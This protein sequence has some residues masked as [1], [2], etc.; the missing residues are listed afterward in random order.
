MDKKLNGSFTVE[1]A[2][3][4]PIVL[5]IM[6][7]L[8][9]LGFYIHDRILL[10]LCAY[11]TG[12]E[13]VFEEKPLHSLAKEKIQMLNPLTIVP[14]STWTEG[15]GGVKV[16]YVGNFSIPF[17]ALTPFIENEKIKET[18]SVC[19]KMKLE[20]MYVVKIV[21]DKLEDEEK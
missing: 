19:G 15:N 12:M 17:T 20:K 18:K 10:G 16:T 13:S 11:Q 6:T 7:G 3:V 14:S 5:F 2:F 8:I 9:Y 4:I 21:T 1:A